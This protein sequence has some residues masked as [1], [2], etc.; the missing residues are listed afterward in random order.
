MIK[1]LRV[2]HFAQVFGTSGSP[3]RSGG[4]PLSLLAASGEASFNALSLG[5]YLHIRI[6]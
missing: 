3:R 5:L 6:Y 2:S 4:R 1:D